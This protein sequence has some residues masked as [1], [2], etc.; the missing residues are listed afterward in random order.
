MT[1]RQRAGSPLFHVEANCDIHDVN[2]QILNCPVPITREGW[3]NRLRSIPMLMLDHEVWAIKE[4]PPGIKPLSWKAFAWKITNGDPPRP[5]AIAVK[6][7][8]SA[9]PIPLVVRCYIASLLLG[10]VKQTR[11]RR[12]NTLRHKLEAQMRAEV[13]RRVER[14]SERLKRRGVADNYH[15]AIEHVAARPGFSEHTLDSWVH[16]RRR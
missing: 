9:E 4:F 12:K 10:Q 3:A 13:A 2:H 6:L 8:A 7:V 16:P 1:V 14:L 11:G 15:V 5:L